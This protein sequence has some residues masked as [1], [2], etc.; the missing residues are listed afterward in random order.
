[1]TTEFKD[2]M[3]EDPLA[4]DRSFLA[5]FIQS[6]DG[7][8]L[9]DNI[10]DFALEHFQE[11]YDEFAITK[12]DIFFYAYGLFHNKTYCEK[13]KNNL[14]KELPYITMAQDFWAHSIAGR[15]LTWFHAFYEHLDGYEGAVVE[16]PL[17]FDLN[18][19]EHYRFEKM[20]W[21]DKPV[22]SVLWI[23]DWITISEIPAECHQ[24]LVSGKS[25]LDW[26]VDRYKVKT[27]KATGIVNDANDLF[28]EP[29][30]NVLL[31]AKQLMEVAIE[32]VAI[33]N[34]LPEDCD[35]R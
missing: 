27:D 10:T 35:G 24:Y 33:V 20:K 4:G 22:K 28:D 11:Q 18:N 31:L 32:T 21:L 19:S 9:E 2:L 12:D 14:R 29:D 25:P 13:Y 6:P 30:K 26:L 8:M 1:M 15:K 7:Y 16:T 17:S 34:A 5:N 23:N 3:W